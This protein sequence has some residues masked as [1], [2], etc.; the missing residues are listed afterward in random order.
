MIELKLLGSTAL[1]GPDGEDL[2]E[3]LSR[4]KRLALLAFLA[5]ERPG[6]FHRRD[7]LASLLWEQSDETHARSSL[8]VTLHHLKRLLGDQVIVKRG[9]RELAIVP[10][11]LRVDVNDFIRHLKEGA[12]EV[13]AKLYRGALLEDFHLTSAPSFNRWLEGKRRRLHL[14]AL[15][16]HNELADEAMAKEPEVAE[17]WARRATTMAPYDE[18][19]HRRL[20]EALAR[21]GHR[22]S[23]LRT[24]ESFRSRL[25][26]ELDLEPSVDL[27]ELVDGLRSSAKDADRQGKETVVTP[28]AS[29]D[30]VGAGP[31]GISWSSF[32]KVLLAAVVTTAVIISGAVVATSGFG[33]ADPSAG[34]DPIDV[35]AAG[36]FSVDR[37]GSGI[38]SLAVLV[39]VARSGG[40]RESH[41]A[42]A[43]HDLLVAELE[44]L[45]EISVT[46][47]AAVG[48]GAADGSTVR[49]IIDELGV[50]AILRGSVL[51]DQDQ[52]LITLELLR[53]VGGQPLWSE[54]FRTS[55]G[56]MPVVQERAA[57]RLVE[58]LRFGSDRDDR[59]R[60][61]VTRPIDPEAVEHYL[62]AS[63]YLGQQTKQGFQRAVGRYQLAIAI[64]STY[65]PA[66]AGLAMAY[67]ELGSWHSSLPPQAVHADALAAATRAVA[68]DSTL[69]EGYVALGRIRHLFEWDW[70]A[71]DTAFR[72]GIELNPTT[73]YALRVYGSYLMA[74][75]RFD[76]AVAIFRR[77]IARDP[78]SQSAH[79]WLAWALDHAGHPE[80]ARETFLASL[81][82]PD[83]GWTTEVLLAEH[84]LRHGEPDAARRYLLGMVEDL[85]ATSS[86]SAISLAAH[87]LGRMGHRAEALSLLGELQ[88]MSRRQWVYPTM[89]AAVHIGVGHTEEALALIESAVAERDVMCVWFRTWWIFDP[90]RD[91]PRF[92]AVMER[93]DFPEE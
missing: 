25:A 2:P 31:G 52:I 63:F 56:E 77:L 74:M 58:W 37:P 36:P 35:P 30:R 18:A 10:E 53:A 82:L 68:L 7:K 85:D 33:G 92:Q 45:D 19:A 23:A 46:S 47:G 81:E 59:D 71:A 54:S 55:L 67:V 28:E 41:V 62:M 83:Q 3:I 76:E 8:S 44:G 4:P 32:M 20:V 16:A 1:T 11:C 91:E 14:L 51:E 49:A 24:F 34:S 29:T 17:R 79:D 12:L 66:Y 88:L 42:A 72:R 78:L 93:M 26:E 57:R 84:H 80:E 27:L 87:L 22:A 6:A 21:S 15:D 39:P 65:A 13:A 70:A 9:N 61:S 89:L 64:D 75:A 60:Q 38:R 90:L 40:Q 5:I 73:S 50:D 43:M 69:A 86:P 48:A